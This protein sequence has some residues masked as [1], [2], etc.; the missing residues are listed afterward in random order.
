MKLNYQKPILIAEIG[1]N[2]KGDINIAMEMIEVASKSGADYAKFQ[3][4]D[5]KY[6]LGNEYN[7]PHPVPE[8]SYGKTYGEHRDKLEFTVLEHQRLANHCIKNKIKY[9]VS[10]WE[11]KSAKS[12]INSNIKLDYIKV[13]SACNLDFE[14]LYFLGK[15]F[16]KKIH[17]SLGMTKYEE[18]KKIYNFFKKLK[19]EKD[20][21]FYSCTSDYPSK[22]ND[23]CLLEISRIKKNFYKK[24]NN[25]G[26]SGHHLGIA[27][28]NAAYT[29]GANYIERHFTLDRTW[30]G[31]DHAA[32]LEPDGLK[33]LKRDLVN[34]F[35]SLRLKPFNGIIKSEL[36][37][38]KKL[39]VFKN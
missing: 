32:S 15:K 37:Q 3:K 22:F 18:I 20:L 36:F 8:N 10:V 9:A 39:K 28:D 33:K 30:K 38:R 27:I 14:L 13:P 4:R 25:F 19:R 16:K 23:V 1:C 7:K 34:T 35:N 31:T 2:H 29:L 11:I 12:I 21:I 6:L 26:F 5:N 17:I 24:I